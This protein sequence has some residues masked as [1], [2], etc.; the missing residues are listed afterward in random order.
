MNALVA[1]LRQV[2]RRLFAAPGGAATKRRDRLDGNAQQDSLT[3]QQR[4]GL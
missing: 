3:Y 2:A 1:K 4:S